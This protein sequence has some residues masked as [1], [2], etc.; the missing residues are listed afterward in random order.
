MTT[1]SATT[2]P[3]RWAIC[4]ISN[5]PDS[6]ALRAMLSSLGADD[7]VWFRPR[8]VEDLDQAIR[9]G[10]FQA[11]VFVD[12]PALLTAIFDGF[13]DYEEWQRQGVRVEFL[14]KSDTNPAALLEFSRT[15]STWSARTRRR[16]TAAS[17][18]LSIV[19]IAAATAL[20]LLSSR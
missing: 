19:A 14:H 8:D 13:V 12:V 10:E 18:I 7:A 11:A 9:R 1:P 16:R 15:W 2:S 5:G 4:A 6:D 3:I 20:V 17:L